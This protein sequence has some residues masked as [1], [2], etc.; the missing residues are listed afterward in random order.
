VE[1]FRKLL[2][3]TIG[4]SPII[5]WGKFIVKSIFGYTI[6]CNGNLTNIL[7]FKDILI[8]RISSK[9]FYNIIVDLTPEG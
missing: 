9:E 8:E 4:N 1:P 6:Q 7:S 2:Y 5:V 3:F